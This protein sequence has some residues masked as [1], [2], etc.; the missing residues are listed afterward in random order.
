MTRT[1]TKYISPTSSTKSQ[2]RNSG[3]DMREGLTC[4]R[5]KVPDPEVQSRRTKD[6]LVS[7]ESARW[8]SG[9]HRRQTGRIFRYPND[10]KIICGKIVE[11]ARAVKPPQSAMRMTVAKVCSTDGPP[12]KLA[13]CQEKTRLSRAVSGGG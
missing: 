12:G 10:A 11:A 8:W 4:I 9:N 3:D 13:D 1:I 5:V 7:S 2:G 6:K